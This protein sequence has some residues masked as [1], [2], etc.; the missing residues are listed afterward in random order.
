M[1]IRQSDR[2]VVEMITAYRAHIEWAHY[3]RTCLDQ[4]M[5]IA[6]EGSVYARLRANL[7]KSKPTAGK[8]PIPSG[9][10]SETER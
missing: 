6:R 3:A 10:S 9:Q 8:G 2:A 7:A 4:A 1:L 5:I